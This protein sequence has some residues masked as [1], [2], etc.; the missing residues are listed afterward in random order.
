MKITVLG[1][2]SW[3]ATIASH[4]AKEGAEVSLWEI[5]ESQVLFMKEKRSLPFLPQLKIPS[6]MVI[7]SRMDEALSGAEAIF[8]IVPSQFVRETW[9]KAGPLVSGNIQLI[10]SLSKGIEAETLKRMTEVIVDET[11]QAK[12]KIAV[13]S[14]PSHAEE[15]ARDVP[16]AVIA[17]SEHK[18]IAELAQ[19]ILNTRTFRVYTSPDLIGAELCGALK[20]IFA[21]AC[22]ACD[23]LGLGDNTKAALMT[24][25]LHE[26]AKLGSALGANQITFFG[27]AG[28]GDLIVTCMSQHSR[29]RLLGEKI[30]KGK[31]A[32]EALKEMTMVAEGYPNAKSAFQLIQKTGCD[33]PLIT[34]IYHVLYNDKDI[35]ESLQDLLSRPLPAY[36]ESRDVPWKNP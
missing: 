11:P 6:S 2:G 7:T 10:V 9:K 4:M 29:N 16:T 27:L 5:V 24:R 36:G 19:K 12:N 13:V 1:G 21:I 31:N 26:M 18:S 35:Q 34:E 14:G 17:A 32:R 3:G 15:V 33:C 23:G 28:M 8:S 30:G 25:G 20:N 22:G